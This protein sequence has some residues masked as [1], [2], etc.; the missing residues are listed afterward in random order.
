MD[1]RRVIRS[2]MLVG[3]FTSLSRVLG[4]VRDLLTAGVFGTS[5]AMS[6]FVV[7]FR[8]PNLFRRL[9]GEGALSSAFVPVYLEARKAD[10]EE[11]ASLL[12]SRVLSL[13]GVGL[14][15]LTAAGVLLAGWFMADVA[16]GSQRALILP[17]S[18][19][20][21][22]YM[23]F[24]CLAA[25]T[26]AMLNAHHRFTVPALAPSLMNITWI[27]AVLILCPLMGDTLEERIFG[28]AWGVLLSGL[29][30]LGM[31]F[32]S[33]R[34]IGFRFRFTLR[35]QDARVWR[36][37]LL[38]GPATIGL[39]VT[40]INVMINSLIAA[41]IGPW[42][43]A[44]LYY[45]ERLLYLPQGILATAMSTV[46]LPVFAGHA[47]E[48]RRDAL[49]DTMNHSLR[50]LTFVMVPAAIGLLVLSRPIIQM[51]FEWGQF[52]AASTDLTTIALQCYA[53]GLLVF[54][55]SKVFVP[56]FYAHQDTR[57]PVLIGIGCVALNLILNIVFVLTLPMHLKHAGLAG[58]TVIAEAA[59]GLVLG[60]FVHRRL[61]SPGWVRIMRG[62][63][64]CLFAAGIMGALILAVLPMLQ[65]A[66]VSAALP[67]KLAQILSVSAVIAGGLLAYLGT[68]RILR[69]PEIGEALAALRRKKTP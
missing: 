66:A 11:A 30:Q 2:A 55:L 4:M 6:A 16:D 45:S 15:T 7:A 59:N 57:T 23:F 13:A 24:I 41:W 20:M 36:V 65:H 63:A 62:A 67:V 46:L 58:S 42:A 10:G 3:A 48:N 60:W 39:A 52:D 32:P 21:L 50:M 51:L 26:A 38:M 17:L 29:I 19:L 1:N 31:Q 61:G 34:R 33:L 64:K 14:L 12:A 56:A 54:S 9:F 69:C 47:A 5:L 40:Q 28:L 25:L 43:P 27:A 49:L 22:P 37:F 53:P 68:A 44:A 35:G 18:R 8:I